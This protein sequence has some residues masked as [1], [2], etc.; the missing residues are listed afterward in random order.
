MVK[1]NLNR[2]EW[3]LGDNKRLL[4]IPLV[5]NYRSHKFIFSNQSKCD[6]IYAYLVA[7]EGLEPP[8]FGLWV[9]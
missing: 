5:K 8:T 7:R 6:K 2:Y 1:I 3:V 4:R 9:F